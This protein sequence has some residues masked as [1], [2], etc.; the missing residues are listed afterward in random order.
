MGA[1]A[2]LEVGIEGPAGE[3]TAGG[4]GVAV[5]ATTPD[6]A[7]VVA[8]AAAFPVVA[9]VATVLLSPDQDILQVK[10]NDT[11]VIVV[12]TLLIV[13]VGMTVSAVILAGSTRTELPPLT[14][15]A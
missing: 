5:E 13:T 10:V 4:E 3:V 15:S 9:V 6:P 11:Q 7:G 1:E 8:A 14:A 12:T 2:F